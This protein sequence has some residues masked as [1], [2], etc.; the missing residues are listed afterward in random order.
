[1]LC[2]FTLFFLK[3]NKYIP[4]TLRIL[5]YVFIFFNN[6]DTGYAMGPEDSNS[7]PSD[8]PTGSVSNSPTGKAPELTEEDKKQIKDSTKK[9]YEDYTDAP[10]PGRYRT[11]DYMEEDN[12]NKRSATVYKRVGDR[13]QSQINQIREELANLESNNSEE[14]QE[15]AIS[16]KKE[17]IDI[18]LEQ[19][20][21]T[22]TETTKTLRKGMETEI[23]N[24]TSVGTKRSGEE[25]S[26]INKKQK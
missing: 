2:Y 24:N 21:L 4:I 15:K 9:E 6:L 26:N 18:L 23:S 10:V 5:C 7:D 8:Q 17:M 13:I 16:D 20:S 14:S 3:Y 22:D 25:S 11:T 1:M 12:S 19:L